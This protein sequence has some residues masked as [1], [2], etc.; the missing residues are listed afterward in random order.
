MKTTTS[1]ILL[2]AALTSLTLKDVHYQLKKHKVKHHEIVFAQIRLETGNLKSKPFKRTNNLFGFSLN[3]K[4]IRYKDI[5]KSIEAYVKWQKKF[6]KGGCYYAFLQSIGYAEDKS[7]IS[8]LKE[9]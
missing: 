9:F 5:S 8:K 2:W 1:I 6:Y 4:L 7:Y 3:G